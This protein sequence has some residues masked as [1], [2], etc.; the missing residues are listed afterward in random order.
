MQNRTKNSGFTLIELLVS[1]FIMLTLLGIVLAN[2]SGLSGTRNLNVAK[3]NIISDMRRQQSQ[4]LSSR[5]ISGAIVASAYGVTMATVTAP[6][7]SYSMIADNNSAIPVRYNQA[8]LNLP[9][10]V[11][12]KTI[13]IVRATGSSTTATNLEVYFT[14]PYGRLLQTYSGGVS[15]Q[16]KDPNAITTVTL[17]TKDNTKTLTFVVNGVSGN[18]TP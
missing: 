12:I 4:S 3:N 9:P 16:S 8:T 15:A 11:Y 10:N 2:F 7:S 13:S 17:S 1:V 18:I 6:P 5:N 14:V